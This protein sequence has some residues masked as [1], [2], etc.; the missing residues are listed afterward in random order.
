MLSDL[1]YEDFDNLTQINTKNINYKINVDTTLLPKKIYEIYQNET[2]DRYLAAI[3]EDNTPLTKMI[4]G[5]KKYK[6]FLPN[7]I[8]S[9]QNP[10]FTN[11]YFLYYNTK[12][13]YHT[14][15]KNAI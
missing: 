14:T 3:L 13:K 2:E 1:E 12:I 5:E 9:F 6:N 4:N 7:I 11:K 10:Y 15:T 8:K